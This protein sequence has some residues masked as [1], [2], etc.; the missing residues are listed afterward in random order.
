MIVSRKQIENFYNEEWS[1]LVSSKTIS[2]LIELTCQ[3]YHLNK[4]QIP[5]FI[6]SGEMLK[7]QALGQI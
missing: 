1:E 2:A 6:K 3:L 4:P 7:P 5:S